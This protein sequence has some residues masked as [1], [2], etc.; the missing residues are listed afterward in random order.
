MVAEAFDDGVAPPLEEIL[1]PAKAPRPLAPEEPPPDI[2]TDEAG[3][4]RAE[5]DQFSDTVREK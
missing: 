1:I 3:V 2:P 5:E 4:K